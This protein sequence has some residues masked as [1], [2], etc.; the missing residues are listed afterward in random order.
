MD[1]FTACLGGGARLIMTL[2]IGLPPRVTR[3]YG[4][5]DYALDVIRNRQLAFVHVSVL[6]DPFDP[7]CFFET[8]FGDKYIN[9]LR[10][11]KQ[12]HPKEISWFRAKVTAESWGKT[13]RD[14]K[15]YLEALRKQSFMLSTSAPPAGL[16]PKDNLYMWGHYGC[17]HRGLAIEFD[18][19]KVAIAVLN[20]HE[21]ENGAPLSEQTVWSKVEYARTFS[22]I[23]AAD[24]YEFIKQE[25]D[26][27]SRRILVRGET[28]LRAYYE[29]MAIIKSDVWQSENE[30]R[31][32]W[33]SRTEEITVYKCPISQDCVTNIFI[34]L[35]HCAPVAE[36]V[37]EAKR[38]F[39][40]AGI[41]RAKKRHGD[42]ALDF[43]EL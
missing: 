5:I 10:Y 6:N 29:R 39:P 16:H 28:K 20:Q 41:F 24:F 2:D 26:L 23:A 17:G 19:E 38:T 37:A 40:N 33:K 22:P 43:E 3:F 4:K 31:L 27:E 14:I 9:L 32:M 34:G 36:L 13:V 35:K 12:H 15:A 21:I 7:Y 18:T 30:W 1:D 25:K 42:L 11:V 8:D